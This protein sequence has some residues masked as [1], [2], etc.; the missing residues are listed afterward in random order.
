MDSIITAT[1]L[2]AFRENMFFCVGNYIQISTDHLFGICLS[3]YELPYI[4]NAYVYQGITHSSI[5]KT[6]LEIFLWLNL[7]V[8]LYQVWFFQNKYIC[9]HTGFHE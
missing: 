4:R 5:C 9:M 8:L 7:F 3:K 2:L 6:V 1:T